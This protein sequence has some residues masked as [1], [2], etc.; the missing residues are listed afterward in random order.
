MEGPAARG[1]FSVVAKHQNVSGRGR[2][3]GHGRCRCRNAENKCEAALCTRSE[4]NLS[5]VAHLIATIYSERM[6]RNGFDK[7]EYKSRLIKTGL[8]EDVAEALADALDGT[9]T[10]GSGNIDAIGKRVLR[11]L[12]I[13]IV[14][15]A[16][17]LALLAYPLVKDPVEQALCDTFGVGVDCA[18]GKA[19][20]G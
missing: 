19:D 9:L 20:N 3:R 13:I 18:S 5:H 6:A 1:D 16:V 11:R 15:L 17:G 7:S 2:G 14:M 4:F 8:S 12:R 10:G